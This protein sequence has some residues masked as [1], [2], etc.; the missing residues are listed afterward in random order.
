MWR[1]VSAD[2]LTLLPVWDPESNSPQQF[3]NNPEDAS[4]PASQ[5]PRFVAINPDPARFKGQEYAEGIYNGKVQR[6]RIVP[7]SRFFYF[8]IDAHTMGTAS[9]S[10]NGRP[11][12][13][14]DYMIFVGMHVTTKEIPN[15]VWATFWWHD[16]PDRGPY[17]AQRPSS[18]LAPWRNY[19]MNVSY[20]MNE[21]RETDGAPH[22]AFNPYLEGPLAGGLKSNC[23]TCHIQ[24]TWKPIQPADT[25][26]GAISPGDRRFA[27]RIRLDF[28][29]T[30]TDI[31]DP[32][33]L[34]RN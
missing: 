29:W 34:A 3:G 14:G 22:I 23:M 5:W 18:V 11:A 4:H 28:M 1:V 15:W 8:R 19:L 17:A 10:L 31:P 9:A 24:A 6:A 27:D 26:P 30:L 16:E 13:P 32:V 33:C 12:R 2:D 25:T 7:L 21:P 20:D